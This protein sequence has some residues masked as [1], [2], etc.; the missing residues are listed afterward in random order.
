MDQLND[1]EIIQICK[2]SQKFDEKCTNEFFEKHI[3]SRLC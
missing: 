3:K 2:N 1:D